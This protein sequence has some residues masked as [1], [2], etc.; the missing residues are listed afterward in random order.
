[1]SGIKAAASQDQEKSRLC[2]SCSEGERV[3]PEVLLTN[4]PA[5]KRTVCSGNPKQIQGLAPF[6]FRIFTGS[7]STTPNVFG[8]NVAAETDNH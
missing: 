8:E 6:L 4:P 2:L 5:L 3:N 7:K 1:M